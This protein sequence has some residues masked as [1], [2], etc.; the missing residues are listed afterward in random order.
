MFQKVILGYGCYHLQ[1][2]VGNG[3]LGIRGV[4]DTAMDDI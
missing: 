4:D 2:R 1:V 3:A